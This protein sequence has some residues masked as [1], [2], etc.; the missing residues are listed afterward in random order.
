MIQLYLRDRFKIISSYISF[1]DY[2]TRDERKLTNKKFFKMNT[3]YD[4]FRKNIRAA[5][6][7]GKNLTI[8]ET[9]FSFR[10]RCSHRQYIKSKPARY[11]LKYNNIVDTTTAYL[12]DSLPYLGKSNEEDKNQTNLGQKMVES[13]SEFYYGSNR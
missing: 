6:I 3:F 2:N 13:L 12:L 4:I 1:D 10:G 5:L 7:P 8:D 9:L 11:G